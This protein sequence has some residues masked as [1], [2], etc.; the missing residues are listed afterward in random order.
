[1]LIAANALCD[2]RIVRIHPDEEYASYWGHAFICCDEC[3]SILAARE[4][5]GEVYA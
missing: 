5:W 3:V 1:M 2:D 4:S